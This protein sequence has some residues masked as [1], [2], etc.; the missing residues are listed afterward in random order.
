M[1]HLVLVLASVCAGAGAGPKVHFKLAYSDRPSPLHDFQ[2][3]PG[4]WMN[5]NVTCTSLHRD[6]LT[7]STCDDGDTVVMRE[8]LSPHGGGV[9]RAPPRAQGHMLPLLVS[10][11]DAQRLSHVNRSLE[12]QPNLHWPLFSYLGTI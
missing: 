12:I 1:R 8:R 5:R 10:R 6:R 4:Y 7:P 11:D 3:L 2:P 9:K